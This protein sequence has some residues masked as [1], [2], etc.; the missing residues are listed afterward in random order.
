MLLSV[1]CATKS[2][3]ASWQVDGALSTT[4]TVRS[5]GDGPSWAKWRGGKKFATYANRW[6][7]WILPFGVTHIVAAVERGANRSADRSLG[8]SLGYLEAVADSIGAAFV[9]VEL[10]TWRRAISEEMAERGTPITWPK[11]ESKRVAIDVARA[12]Y[13]QLGEGV[14]DDEAEAVLIGHAARRLRLVTP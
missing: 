8:R 6:Q 11:G 12:L 2:G 14:T 4:W 1:D 3:V 10:S 5:V 7:A 9:T 13:P